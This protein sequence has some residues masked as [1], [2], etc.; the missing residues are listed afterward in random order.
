MHR[1]QS[2]P[3]GVWVFILMLVVV[4]GFALGYGYRQPSIAGLAATLEERGKQLIAAQEELS[5]LEA[6]EF[7]VRLGL[8]LTQR[9][10]RDTQTQLQ[11]TRA[12]LDQATDESELLQA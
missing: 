11:E 5:S 2:S 4:T 9:S 12:Q 6:A 1:V 8:T 10:L 3:Y 7:Q